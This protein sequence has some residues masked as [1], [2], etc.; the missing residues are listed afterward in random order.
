MY[1]AS[2]SVFPENGVFF[3]HIIYSFSTKPV[4]SGWLDIGSRYV[5]RSWGGVE[6]KGATFQC[7]FLKI[8]NYV[9]EK[10]LHAGKIRYIYFFIGI[11]S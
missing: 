4:W 7:K 2:Y 5:G 3:F 11:K 9:E 10:N 8:G 1:L 6:K